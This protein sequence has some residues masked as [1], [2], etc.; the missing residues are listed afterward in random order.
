M[1]TFTLTYLPGMGIP[2]V[3]VGPITKMPPAPTSTRSSLIVPC[4]AIQ[5]FAS[6]DHI[7]DILVMESPKIIIQW[8]CWIVVKQCS[9]PSPHKI[10][11]MTS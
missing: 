10:I 6:R 4:V 8:L 9:R 1:L 3:V 5:A 2:L 7:D 11:L